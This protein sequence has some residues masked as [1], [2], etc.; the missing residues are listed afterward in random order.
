[1]TKATKQGKKGN[2]DGSRGPPR[3]CWEAKYKA[4][5]RSNNK[6]ASKAQSNNNN[7]FASSKLE[8][9]KEENKKKHSISNVD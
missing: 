5:L 1:M 4:K 3:K 8:C 7:S 2:G 6:K 9:S